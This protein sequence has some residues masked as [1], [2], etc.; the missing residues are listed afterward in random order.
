MIFF[1]N[2]LFFKKYVFIFVL[3]LKTLKMKLKLLFCLMLIPAILSAQP[4]ADRDARPDATRDAYL[5]RTYG[6]T[7]EQCAQYARLLSEEYNALEKLYSENITP[8]ILNARKKD[9]L[10][11]FR[12]KVMKIMT[13]GQYASWT[14][15]CLTNRSRRYHEYLGLDNSG[16]LAINRIIK[17]YNANMKK[18]YSG[19]KIYSNIEK[20]K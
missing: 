5:K 6:M 9:L 15:S 20:K 16:V 2:I 18:R 1:V 17:E 10:Q 7:D 14:K 8:A 11:V 19:A 3:K 4:Y 13:P 12:L